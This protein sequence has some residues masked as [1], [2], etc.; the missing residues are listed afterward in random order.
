MAEIFKLTPDTEK[1]ILTKTVTCLKNSGIVIVPTDTVYGLVCDGENEKAKQNIYLIKGRDYNKP[2]IGFINDIEK[3]KHFAIIPEKFFPFITSRWPGRHTFVFKSKVE[4]PFLVSKEKTIGLRIPDFDFVRNLCIHFSL[5]A[6]TSANVSQTKSASG[7]EE[8]DRIII[9]N[10]SMTVEGGFPSG[11][12]S[13]IWDMTEDIPKLIRGSI[14][15]VCSGN[16]CR[17]PMAQ[18][19]AEKMICNARIKIFSAGTDIGF[20]NR[21]SQETIDVLKEIGIDITGFISSPVTEQMLAFSDLIFVMEEKHKERIL[22][23][24]PQAEDKT[25]V[26]DVPDPA[27]G[28]IFH[29]RQIR[30]IITNRI[31]NFVLTRIKK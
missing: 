29:Y 24:F 8:I 17:S 26:L 7:L 1:E 3:A 21:A 9:E 10:V 4:V 6:S 18:A 13:A 5:I 16:S 31:K 20:Y 11:N 2:L 30:D 15:F 12:E 28:N 27:G 19:I 25:F 22:Q 23:L 14:L